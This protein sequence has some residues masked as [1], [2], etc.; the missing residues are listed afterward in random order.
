MLADPNGS[1]PRD[2]GQT[3]KIYN[4]VAGPKEAI[5]I[6][7]SS[8][9]TPLFQPMVEEAARY[10]ASFREHPNKD[11]FQDDARPVVRLGRRALRREPG[12][13]GSGRPA[14]SIPAVNERAGSPVTHR[15]ARALSVWRSP[16]P[17]QCATMPTLASIT[18]T[19]PARMIVR[20]T[21]PPKPA[22]ALAS[23]MRALL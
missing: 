14:R 4:L 5:D 12:E 17:R 1:A 7:G 15:D 6:F 20:L 3:P 19:F 16:R 18:W 9:G 11:Y 10:M 23:S 21:A 2:F 22:P 8:G 13:A